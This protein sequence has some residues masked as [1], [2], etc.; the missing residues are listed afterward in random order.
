MTNIPHEF[1]S[2]TEEQWKAGRSRYRCAACRRDYQDRIHLP[3]LWP[4]VVI[5]EDVFIPDTAADLVEGLRGVDDESL[6]VTIAVWAI[7]AAEE[8]ERYRN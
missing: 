3:L 1:E 2:I 5:L 4:L 7:N 6:A 8:I